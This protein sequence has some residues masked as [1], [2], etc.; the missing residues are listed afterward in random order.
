MA[1]RRNRTDGQERWKLFAT[2]QFV[3]RADTETV[4][5]ADLTAA[6]NC[7]LQP[8]SFA[9][10][11]SSPAPPKGSHGSRVLGKVSL[12]VSSEGSYPGKAKQDP[13]T[14]R[15]MLRVAF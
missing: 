5:D 3:H 15:V 13:A 7:S 8:T 1:S 11:T 10:Q 6:Q 2:L 12:C 4:L 14:G 9:G